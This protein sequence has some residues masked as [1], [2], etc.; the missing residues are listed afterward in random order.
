MSRNLLPIFS[1][2]SFMISSFTCCYSVAQLHPTL[3]N[4]MVC[5]TPGFPVLHQLQELAQTHVHWVSDAVQLSHPL[6]SPSPP[7][8]N[9]SRIRVFSNKLALHIRWLKILIRVSASV[10]PVNIQGWFPLW[11]AGVISLMFKGVSGV[12]SAPQFKGINSL[13]FCQRIDRV[14]ITYI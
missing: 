1:S 8:L 3:C 13:A 6:L 2:M 5:S 7:A 12:F 4:P 11:L 10:L 14:S 9:L